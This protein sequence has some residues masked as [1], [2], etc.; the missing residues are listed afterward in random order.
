MAEKKSKA[1]MIIFILI[2]VFALLITGFE[3]F[4]LV[5]NKDKTDYPKFEQVF[6]SFNKTDSETNIE[7]DLPESYS[8]KDGYIGKII[9]K[10]VIQSENMTYNQN[11]LL[12]TI[13]NL[14]KDENNKALVVYIDSPGGS[15][16]ESD[17]VYLALM[18]YKKK[19]GRP[20]FA[21]F[22]PVAASG[23]YYIACASDY[24]VANRNTLT[25][26]IGVI[27]GQ[28]TDFT[29]FMEKHG[30]KS[31]TIHSGRNK[32]MGAINE[33]MTQEQKQIMQSISDECYEQ[34]TSIVAEGRKLTID[35]VKRLADGRIYTAKQAQNAK[36]IDNIGTFD[37]CISLLESEYFNQEKQAVITYEY[38][39]SQNF[40][41]LIMGMSKFSKNTK[42][43]SF[44]NYVEQEFSKDISYPA[45]YF[46]SSRF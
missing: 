20:I 13:K 41:N 19:T 15:V 42:T 14:Q 35:E 3:I 40:R 18:D 1:G 27:S 43:E 32:N 31:T 12:N 29:G 23:G 16:Y 46:D 44:E 24:I 4:S 8:K 38:K 2:I 39:K 21:Y 26:S 10:G 30:I 28:F 5:K 45:Y 34:F 9:I 36:L 11:W 17:E 22:G 6:K 37:D 7:K 25:G 33:P